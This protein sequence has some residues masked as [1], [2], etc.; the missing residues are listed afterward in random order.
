MTVL[1][2]EDSSRQLRSP[3]AINSLREGCR[4]P[5][6]GGCRTPKGSVLII[7]LWSL[8]L[9]S[10]FAVYLGYGVRQ[11]LV[12]AYR[13]DERSKL[14][15]IADAGIKKAVISLAGEEFVEGYASLSDRWSDNA[16]EFKEQ[17][18]GDGSF[19][20]SHTYIN[21]ISNEV[22]VRY[23]L[24]DEES[25]ININKA[26]QKILRS[27]F[28]ICLDCDEDE[29]QR[30]AASVVDWRDGDSALSIPIGSAED[31]D[32]RGLQYSYEAKDA[33]FEVP[34]EVLL[35]NGMNEDIFAKVKDYIT[36]YGDGKVNINTASKTVLLSLGLG[37][38]IV[39][40]IML[41]RYGKDKI[42]GTPDDGV[43]TSHATIAP[44]LSQSFPLSE[45]QLAQLTRVVDQS[46]IT[47]SSY[48]TIRCTSRLNN[49]KNTT[50]IICVVDRS[51]KIL[52][53][54]ES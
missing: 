23:G 10:V 38:D 33:D 43:F 17:P 49:K 40:N 1:R 5:L 26:D 45:S 3:S 29:A 52:Y 36:I 2:A 13:L 42:L 46:L 47:G 9:L 25:K 27:L 50:E 28:R 21:D 7:T 4:T 18:I 20:I 39:Y 34:E 16:V 41:F 12:L 15:F 22:F 8:F 51:G 31:A 19:T 35:V 30:L 53:W 48:F 11:K 37:G 14:R 54:H 32:Y 44:Q 6:R 24:V